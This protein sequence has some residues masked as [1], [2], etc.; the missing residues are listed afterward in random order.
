M[1]I[2]LENNISFDQKKSIVEQ[3][4][5]IKYKITEVHT[6]YADYLIA[7]GKS[8]FDIRKLGPVARY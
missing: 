3:I 7:I 5:D 4:K 2:Q 8:E 6:Q 1:I